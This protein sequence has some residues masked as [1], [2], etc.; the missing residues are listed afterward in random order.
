VLVV[1][2]REL[3]A[4][5]LVHPH[6]DGH[7]KMSRTRVSAPRLGGPPT[8]VGR[9]LLSPGWRSSVTRTRCRRTRTDRCP[10]PEGNPDPHGRREG[11]AV[12][13]GPRSQRP[14]PPRGTGALTFAGFA[15][16]PSPAGRCPQRGAV[17]FVE[18][19]LRPTSKPVQQRC[20]VRRRAA[21]AEGRGHPWPLGRQKWGAASGRP[22]Y[23]PSMSYPPPVQRAAAR[24]VGSNP[25][26][27]CVVARLPPMR[28]VPRWGPPHDAKGPSFGPA[29]ATR[30]LGG[31]GAPP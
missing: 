18:A 14:A 27:T 25:P 23:S 22:L 29:R 5:D 31:L 8:N 11:P 3:V 2:Q 9:S 20:A 12:R 15:R 28:R 16:H 1:Q 4:L 13:P 30:V 17:A 21:T 6:P 24:G 7:S 26:A 10:G 19:V